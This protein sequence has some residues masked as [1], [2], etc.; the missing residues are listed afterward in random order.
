MAKDKS[1]KVA[2]VSLQDIMSKGPLPVTIGGVAVGFAT[3]KQFSTGS[4]GFGFNGPVNLGIGEDK[5]AMCQVGLNVTV[6]H[7]KPESS[8]AA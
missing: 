2:S 4:Y 7:S 8:E 1:K 5:I 6:K 3:P